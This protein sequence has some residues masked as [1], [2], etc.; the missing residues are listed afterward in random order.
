MS[1]AED[2]D[3]IS[4]SS[5]GLTMKSPFLLIAN[6][7]NETI[8]VFVLFNVYF[9]YLPCYRF[10]YIYSSSLTSSSS[11]TIILLPYQTL[12][13]KIIN[14]ILT[15]VQVKV[16]NRSIKLWERSLLHLVFKT[17]KSLRIQGLDSDRNVGYSIN[18]WINDKQVR[19]NESCL[20]ISL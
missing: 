11:S 16:A 18:R 15:S 12:Y 7:K 9:Y 17:I 19:M 2:S 6:I 14:Q 1:S 3:E 10:Y 13:I 8:D 4:S 20:S 5:L